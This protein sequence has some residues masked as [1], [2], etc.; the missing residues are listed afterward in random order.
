M[1]SDHYPCPKI[2][3]NSTGTGSGT[4]ETLNQQYRYQRYQIVAE[5]EQDPEPVEAGHVG[6]GAGSFGPT[7]L[8]RRSYGPFVYT[9]IFIMYAF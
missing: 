5:P 3:I 2:W 6:A 1:S 9:V 7:R 4:I 8:L